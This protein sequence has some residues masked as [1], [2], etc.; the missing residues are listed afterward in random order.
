[1]KSETLKPETSETLKPETCANCETLLAE[2]SALRFQLETLQARILDLT[3]IAEPEPADVPEPQEHYT[4]AEFIS[5]CCEYLRQQTGEAVHRSAVEIGL[6]QA[7][8]RP[9]SLGL[10]TEVH[11]RRFLALVQ[12]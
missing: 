2:V 7:K 11:Y 8:I 12:I 5:R 9:D 6:R 1:M 10:Y 3:A 4:R